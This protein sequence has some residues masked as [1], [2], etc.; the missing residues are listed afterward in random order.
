MNELE[1]KPCPFC[2][3]NKVKV[4]YKRRRTLYGSYYT[5]AYVC[6]GSCSSRGPVA[7]TSHFFENELERMACEMWNRR[8]NGELT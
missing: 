5:T 1:L 2:S 8:M 6:C 4:R 7:S 3:S